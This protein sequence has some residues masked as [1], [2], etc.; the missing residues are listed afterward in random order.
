MDQG[1]I[2]KLQQLISRTEK[3][4]I[5]RISTCE[6]YGPIIQEHEKKIA[7]LQSKLDRVARQGTGGGGGGIGATPDEIDA[8]NNA[9]NKMHDMESELQQLKRD[10]SGLD[11]PKIK[12]DI[13][14]LFKITQNIGSKDVIEQ[15]KEDIR[16]VKQDLAD[17]EYEINNA[18][19]QISKTDK[20]LKKLDNALRKDISSNRSRIDQ[21]DQQMS[22]LKKSQANA[23]ARRARLNESRASPA[24]SH[25]DMG[26]LSSLEE[27]LKLLRLDHDQL[28][29]Q[30]QKALPQI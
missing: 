8:W 22:S 27:E 7:D 1:A 6:D 24:G 2:T 28:N 9:A 30:V 17:R 15:L 26:D 23:E 18:R 16:R 4:L 13:L 10:M 25:Q 14:Q 29:E 20:E 5:Q 11:G 21:L 3:Q 12:A 19:E